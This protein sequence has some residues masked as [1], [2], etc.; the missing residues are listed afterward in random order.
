MFITEEHAPI[1]D[2][3]VSDRNCPWFNADLK[4]LMR[5]RDRLKKAAVSTKSETL[6]ESY[7]EARNRVNSLNNSLKKKL[8]KGVI[9]QNGGNTKE[10]WE[11]ANDLLEKRK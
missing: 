3:R 9:S 4:T 2:I 10:T 8:Y 5:S 1:R 7:R 11:R 6:M